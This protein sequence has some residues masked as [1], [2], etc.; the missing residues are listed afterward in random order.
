MNK[1]LIKIETEAYANEYPGSRVVSPD[2]SLGFRAAI[3][4][5]RPILEKSREL[6]AVKIRLDTISAMLNS[7]INRESMDKLLELLKQ[8]DEISGRQ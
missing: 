1:K 3:R 7:D 8:I 6:I 2:F 5:F 4:H